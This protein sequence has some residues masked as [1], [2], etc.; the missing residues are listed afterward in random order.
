MPHYQLPI[1]ST[2]NRVQGQP[3]LPDL[4]GRRA[5]K[6]PAPIDLNASIGRSSHP[7]SGPKQQRSRRPSRDVQA[8]SNSTSVT[9]RFVS[10]EPSAREHSGR[11]SPKK[12]TVVLSG[13]RQSS[14]PTKPSASVL[15]E[16]ASPDREPALPRLTAKEKLRQITLGQLIKSKRTVEAAVASGE[17]AIATT[18]ERENVAAVAVHDARRASTE[19]QSWVADML[20]DFRLMQH[21]PAWRAAVTALLPD[22]LAAAGG[23]AGGSA[24][25]AQEVA[26][27][28]LKQLEAGEPEHAAH[29]AALVRLSRGSD[30][31]P[32]AQ[33]L[34]RGLRLRT[35][36]SHVRIH[37]SVPAQLLRAEQNP[38]SL[39]VAASTAEA[40]GAVQ[41]LKPHSLWHPSSSHPLAKDA[42]HVLSTG[43]PLLRWVSE[44]QMPAWYIPELQA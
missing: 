4:S 18:K 30:P 32:L 19:V 29:R 8:W 40:V 6:P 37:A 9:P 31:R 1:Q 28:L 14:D 7:S 42:F 13:A 11:P 17:E 43:E 27:L 39:M 5:I 36:H 44:W 21:Q 41:R 16:M 25:S 34:A 35:C 12:S 15:Y 38:A 22:A 33:P 2:K 10:R 24:T 26:R 3:P 23:V 20:E